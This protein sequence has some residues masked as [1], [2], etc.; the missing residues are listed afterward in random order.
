MAVFYFL[1]RR[2]SGNTKKLGHDRMRQNNRVGTHTKRS[3]REEEKPKRRNHGY[4]EEEDE[5]PKRKSRTYE[6]EE[7]RKKNKKSNRY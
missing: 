7:D 1:R 4:E 2:K 3:Q 6:D 5:R